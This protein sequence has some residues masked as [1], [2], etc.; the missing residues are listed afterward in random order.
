MDR[1]VY[2]SEEAAPGTERAVSQVAGVRLYDGDTKTQVEDA[3]L[4]LTSHRL[5][6]RAHNLA[7]DLAR[8]AAAAREEGGF[9]RSDKISLSLRPLTASEAARA[10]PFPKQRSGHVKLSFRSGGQQEF[11]AQLSRV[12]E[13]KAWTVVARA[14]PAK[15]EMRAGITGIEKNLHQRAKQDNANISKAFEDLN[16]L[17]EMAKPMVKLAQSISTKIREKQGE[18]TEDETIQFKSYLLSMGI[19]DPITRG[20][21]SDTEYHKLLA[22]E[23]FLILDQPIQEAGGMI[24]LTDAFVRV[25]RARGLELVSPEDILGAASALRDTQLPMKLQRF[26]SGV[27]VLTTSTHSDEEVLGSLMNQLE[28]AGSLTPEEM[29]RQVRNNYQIMI[30]LF[31]MCLLD[32]GV[33]D[34][35]PG[36]A[37]GGGGGGPPGEGRHGGGAQVLPEQV[38]C[39]VT[40]RLFCTLI[41]CFCDL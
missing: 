16:K 33:C 5:L 39:L 35:G 41:I 28:S 30:I 32:G 31:T 40:W 7:L 10:R 36:A 8:V 3:V 13:A 18:I 19:D 29:S 23:M 25:N 14:A 22:Q 20:S 9:L 15:R 6:V 17:M 27:L 21:H 38:P 11:W 24:T 34:P 37:A 2:L 12:L 26:E 1:W 4:E